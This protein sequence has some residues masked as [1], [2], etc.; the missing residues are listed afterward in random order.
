[1]FK[2]MGAKNPKDEECG[3]EVREERTQFEILY[4]EEQRCLQR[5]SVKWLL[6]CNENFHL[7]I[8]SSVNFYIIPLKQQIGLFS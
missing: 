6:I 4:K 1:M 3:Q 7:P 2:S 8:K 5:N